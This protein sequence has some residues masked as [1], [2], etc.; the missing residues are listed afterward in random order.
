MFQSSEDSQILCHFLIHIDHIA[1]IQTNLLNGT[2]GLLGPRLSKRFQNCGVPNFEIS[3]R[4]L[5]NTIWDLFL[6]CLESV[7]GFKVEY[8]WREMKHTGIYGE[9]DTSREKTRRE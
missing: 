9:R 6:N 2:S 8:Y 1:K 7:G 4:I 5:F 3:K